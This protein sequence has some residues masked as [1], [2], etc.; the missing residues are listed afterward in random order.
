MTVIGDRILSLER[1]V[2]SYSRTVPHVLQFPVQSG[3]CDSDRII[4][5]L[6]EKAKAHLAD[7]RE[8][9]VYVWFWLDGADEEPWPLYV[10][11][12]QRGQSSFLA[13]TNAHLSHAHRGVDSLYA[14]KNDLGES[15]FYRTHQAG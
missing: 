5:T 1:W 11:K 3:G 9:G 8:K 6:R 4:K 15:G 14:R 2:E 7:R 13:R 10:G 12:S